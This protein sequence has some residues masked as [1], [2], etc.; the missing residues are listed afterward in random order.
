M[1]NNIEFQPFNVQFQFKIVICLLTR[2]DGKLQRLL[3]QNHLQPLLTIIHMYLQRLR[4][5]I[6]GKVSSYML[7]DC[8]SIHEAS[9]I[10]L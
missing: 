5:Q 2:H 4:R 9:S 7:H 10:L 6:A 1:L 8:S 3:K